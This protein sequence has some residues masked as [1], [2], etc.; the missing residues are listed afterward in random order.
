MP[1]SLHV[2]PRMQVGAMGVGELT[3]LLCT[4]LTLSLIWKSS[5]NIGEVLV[6]QA[7]TSGKRLSVRLPCNVLFIYLF[8]FCMRLK[9]IMLSEKAALKTYLQYCS[10]YITFLIG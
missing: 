3:H 5:R 2:P 6:G 7:V 4:V 10:I 9:R 1:S 8:I